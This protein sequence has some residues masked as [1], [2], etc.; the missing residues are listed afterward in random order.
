MA[1][2]KGEVALLD[3]LTFEGAV[4]RAGGSSSFG[5]NKNAASRSIK[6]M[7]GVNLEADKVAYQLHHD[8]V[9]GFGVI[10]GMDEVSGFFVDRDD[11]L[12]LVENVER[13]RVHG[14]EGFGSILDQSLG[15]G[16]IDALVGDGLTASQLVKWLREGLVSGYEMRLQH[17]TGDRFVAG[18]ALGDNVFEDGG[19]LLLFFAAVGMG[20]VDHDGFGKVGFTQDFTRAGDARLVVVRPVFSATQ[21]EVAVWDCRAW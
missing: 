15:G 19:H 11:P 4:E 13:R 16:P 3:L 8:H 18:H 20:S 2:D 10:G 1:R 14:L 17:R 7:G 12:V 21:N 5:K 6:T 9:V